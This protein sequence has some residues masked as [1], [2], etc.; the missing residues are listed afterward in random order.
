MRSFSL[1]VLERMALAENM[2]YLVLRSEQSSI[3]PDV[4]ASSCHSQ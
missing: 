3:K 1:D 2:L 4:M